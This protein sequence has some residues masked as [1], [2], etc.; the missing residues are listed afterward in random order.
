MNQGRIR[1]EVRPD[2]RGGWAVT[3]NRIIDGCFSSLDAAK[4]YASACARRARRAGMAVDL[5][6]ALP[7]PPQQPAPH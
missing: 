3:R 2:I 4:D 6:I 5:D 7:A 1:I